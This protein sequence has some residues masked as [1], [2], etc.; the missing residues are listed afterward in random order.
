MNHD[1]LKNKLD[2]Y[3]NLKKKQ[4]LNNNLDNYINFKKKQI[5]N[6][7]YSPD[8]N[9][10]K[11]LMI[12]ASHCD[13][14]IKLKTITNNLKFFDYK[15]IDIAFINTKDLYYNKHVKDICDI[16]KNITYYEIENSPTYDFGKW[17]NILNQVDYD[18][19]N[20]IIFTND[21]FIIHEPINYF[22]NLTYKYNVELYGYNDS[23]QRNYHYQSY[24]FSLN[25]NVIP[26]F[27]GNYYK[28]KNI[29]K[30]QE[31]VVT[32]YE[33]KMTDL[34]STK[35]SFLSIGN[36]HSHKGLNIFFTNDE[37]Y[38]KLKQ[39]R[40]LPFSKIKRIIKLSPPI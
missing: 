9:N 8:N 21:S 10:I 2:A 23:T 15:S 34:F 14:E 29:I 31:D 22:F 40:L 20:F 27:I 24:L 39:T 5:L 35:K 3:F 32:E 38:N 28:K 33:L 19:Y 30:C 18:K 11:Y 12:F 25:K 26:I 17:I 37:L 7:N 16:Y 6:N 4:I 1:T 13:S 36:I